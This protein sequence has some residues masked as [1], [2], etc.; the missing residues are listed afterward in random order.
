MGGSHADAIT[1]NNIMDHELIP[2]DIL[3]LAI[4]YTGALIRIC[5]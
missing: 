3:L 4:G 1:E 5:A 2:V